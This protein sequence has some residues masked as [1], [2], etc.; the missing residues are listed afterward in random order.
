MNLLMYYWLSVNITKALYQVLYTYHKE[1]TNLYI[2]N[3]EL[4]MRTYTLNR[5]DTKSSIKIIRVD[6]NDIIL[7]SVRHNFHLYNNIILL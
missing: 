2:G 4:K 3:N 5:F 6:I 1:I 7:Y